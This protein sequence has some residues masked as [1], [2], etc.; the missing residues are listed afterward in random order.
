MP[1]MQRCLEMKNNGSQTFEK[2]A[3]KCFFFSESI[4]F[5]VH[6][7]APQAKKKWFSV[8]VRGWKVDFGTNI[9]ALHAKKLGF[10]CL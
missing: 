9:C 4:G 10:Q 2:M 5:S 8:L 7:R 1:I 6:S 3:P